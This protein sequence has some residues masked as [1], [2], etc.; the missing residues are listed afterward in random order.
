MV[1]DRSTLQMG[2]GIPDA[3]V[4]CLHNHA[5]HWGTY[6]KCSDRIID[7]VEEDDHNK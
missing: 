4:K 7:L 3:V 5:K 2:I 6:G 1:E